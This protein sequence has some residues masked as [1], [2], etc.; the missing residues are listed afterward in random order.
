MRAILRRSICTAPPAIFRRGD[1]SKHYIN[2]QWV[3][4]LA[5][6]PELLPVQNPATGTE[7]CSVALG[8]AADVDAAVA[9]ASAAFDSWSRS[10]VPERLDLLTRVTELYKSR[11]G[12][13][14]RA[15]SLE[16]GAPSSL[17]KSAQTAAGYGHLRAFAEVLHE[18]DFEEPVSS[19]S[20]RGANKRGTAELIRYEPIGVCAL[21][22][23]WNWPMNQVTLK[24]I[25]ALVAGN[26]VVLKPSE[27]A[28]MSSVVF[29]ELM[30]EAGFPSGVFNLVQGDGPTVGHA[31]AA[32][33]DVD[34][35]SFTG[36]T[37]AGV[38]VSKAAAETVKRVALELGGKGPNIIFSDVGD[39]DGD[40][41]GDGLRTAVTRGVRQCMLN[42]GQSCN[43]P[44]RMLVEQ[45]SYARAVEIAAEVGAAV[46][47]GSP[48]EEGHHIGP[49][50]SAAQ[51][52]K[53]QVMI[54]AGLSEGA[55]L[56][57]GGLG[58]PDGLKASGLEAG[59]FC[60]PTI[61]ADVEPAMTIAREEIFGPV[62]SMMPFVDE[63]D[64][65]RLA[66][67]TAY[68]LTSYLQTTSQERIRR[69]V[70]K[71]RAGMVEVNGERR[72][73]K[74]PFGGVRQSGNGREGGAWGLREFL[75]VKSITGYP[76]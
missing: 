37:R 46:T 14:A 40:A 65:I 9:A 76:R 61:F 6:P 8:T 70:P 58:K 63:A 26:T 49:V 21:I 43:A 52:E 4:P 59:Y 45:G 66:N 54:R 53:V 62:L 55:R 2:N 7:V 27:V 47:V 74:A 25:P 32:H 11:S 39:A 29:A 56:L 75:E 19:S 30:E 38:A 13:M 41:G 17:S 57:C 20:K 3:T 69:V 5:S 36:S 1:P 33:A 68:G 22:T 44:S 23:P 42:T 34:M 50:A 28:P 51:F 48:A 12:D 16:M 10:S 71:L 72:S 15:I 18:F 24:V 35:V 31:L 64:A 60:K 67:E 73:A